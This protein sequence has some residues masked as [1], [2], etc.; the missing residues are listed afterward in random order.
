MKFKTVAYRSRTYCVAGYFRWGKN[1]AF[2]AFRGKGGKFNRRNFCCVANMWLV[3]NET[4]IALLQYLQVVP[5]RGELPEL[6]GPLSAVSQPS[7]MEAANAAV[8]AA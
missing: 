1:F 7:A 5:G 4:K 3:A 6:D 8:S 2:F